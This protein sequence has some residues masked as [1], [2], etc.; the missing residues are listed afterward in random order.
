MEILSVFS[1]E[2]RAYG[3]VVEGYPVK[4]L[5]DAL[6]QTPLTDGVVYV[7]REP[8]LHA[9]PEAQAI[10]EAL[11]GGMPFQLGWCNGHNT[12]L[13]CLEFHRD[14]EFNLGTE[15]FILLLGLQGDIADGRMDTATVKAF[16]CP[17][18]V[19]IEVYATSLHYAPCHTDPA[20]GFRVMVALPE[21]TNTDYRP[22]GGA[23]VM[24]RML[25]ARNKWLLAHAESAEAA[26][27]AVV[28]LDG[29]NIDIAAEL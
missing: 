18:G 6:A 23:N 20:K 29:V 2:F 4:G 15:D 25:W 7:P 22:E 10:G 11:Y 8:L 5:L 21:N 13:N 17:A 12:K 16:R 9:A 14:S 1:P 24:D 28:A 19:L 26:Q 3:R 27:G